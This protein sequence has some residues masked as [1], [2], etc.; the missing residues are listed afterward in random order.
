MRAEITE[1]VE[2]EEDPETIRT[3]GR[4]PEVVRVQNISSSHMDMEKRS[5]HSHTKWS[6]TTSSNLY[7]VRTGTEKM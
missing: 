1:E 2:G 4:T 3:I 7:K 6:R 5:Q